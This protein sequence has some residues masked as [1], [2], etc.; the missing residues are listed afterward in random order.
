MRLL[1]KE[2]EE[3]DTDENFTRQK[4]E[5][6]QR[7]IQVDKQKAEHTSEFNKIMQEINS[8]KV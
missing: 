6:I 8:K 5:I 1:Q 3:R 2:K 7:A 4:E